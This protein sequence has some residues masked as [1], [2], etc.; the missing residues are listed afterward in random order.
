MHRNGNTIFFSAAEQ[1]AFDVASEVTVQSAL[2]TADA[3]IETADKLGDNVTEIASSGRR[4]AHAEVTAKMRR[5]AELMRFSGGILS[6]CAPE[7]AQKIIDDA[8]RSIQ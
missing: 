7:I 3:F 2:E 8:N 1:V 6:L 4:E 5:S